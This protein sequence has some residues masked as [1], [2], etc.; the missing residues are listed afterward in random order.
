MTQTSSKGIVGI[1]CG[2]TSSSFAVQVGLLGRQIDAAMI[3]KQDQL[4]AAITQLKDTLHSEGEEQLQGSSD[5]LKLTM[6]SSADALKDHFE[7]KV[8]SLRSAVS[9]VEG[10]TGNAESEP[11]SAAQPKAWAAEMDNLVNH[12]ST[13]W[14]L[15]NLMSII[16][17]R[18]AYA[19]LMCLMTV[20][21]SGAAAHSKGN[22]VRV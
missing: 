8:L 12:V 17:S 7:S 4:A 6:T 2:H 11:S 3:A 21:F 15:C 22:Q 19:S 20:I 16:C 5:S 14:K 13:C 10:R 1:S 18:D 9:E